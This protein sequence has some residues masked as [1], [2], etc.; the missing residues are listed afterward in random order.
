MTDHPRPS[1]PANTPDQW[2]AI[3]R[4]LA[5]EAS[6]GEA[7]DARL[8]LSEHP[9][10]ARVVASLDALLPP[11]IADAQLAD[12]AAGGNAAGSA[13]PFGRPIDVESALRRVHAQ[14]L[15]TS[16]APALTVSRQARS[17]RT[18]AIAMKRPHSWSKVGWAA[19]AALVAGVAVTNWRSG[20]KTEAAVLTYNT[21]VGTSDSVVLSDGSK[22]ILAAGSRLIVAANY[23]NGQRNVE[24]QGAGQFTVKHDARRPFSVRSGSAVIRDLG[25]TFT[26]KAVDGAGV[27]V[28]VSEG[29]VSL[30]DSTA[31]HVGAAVNLLAG[32]RG[33]LRADGTV[34]SERGSVTPDEA[35]WVVGKLVYRDA[36]LAE[37]QADLRRWYG[38]ELIVRDPTLA[39]PTITTQGATNE[40]AVK[41][42]EKLAFSWGGVVIQRGDTLF[43]E[44][45]GD[46]P[47][48]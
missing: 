47:K 48:H 2:D 26:V 31:T 15:T 22:V 35:A 4:F 11:S 40:P 17:N 33:R 36:P 29:S 42:A 46:R 20:L 38:V 39:T 7:A 30:S 10:D 24:L 25:T 5:G 14:M 19:A 8:W 6:A 23:G 44:R 12:T 37:V 21:P 28:A 18:P 1:D 27:V 43:V 32:D 3:A 13:L 45:S 34:L 41:L 16:T 9:D